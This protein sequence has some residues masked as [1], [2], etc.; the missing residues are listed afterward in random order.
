MEGCT[1]IEVPLVLVVLGWVA[2]S[3]IMLA[4]IAG[5]I[6]LSLEFYDAVTTK[7]HELKKNKIKSFFD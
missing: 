1:Q 4:I 6:M 3:A 5:V 7:L 2:A